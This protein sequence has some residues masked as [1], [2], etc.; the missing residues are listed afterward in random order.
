MRLLR[1]D[2]D[3]VVH[4][5]LLPLPKPAPTRGASFEVRRLDRDRNI[6]G[7]DHCRSVHKRHITRLGRHDVAKG[8]RRG[9]ETENS[10]D[11]EVH[12]SG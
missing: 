9:P 5:G 8:S 6:A 2:W 1:W 3:H 4:L 7:H 12:R 11:R 10:R